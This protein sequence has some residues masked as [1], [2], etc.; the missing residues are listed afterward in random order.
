VA[1]KKPGIDRPT[2]P[3]HIGYL[4][5]PFNAQEL[6]KVIRE[7]VPGG[8]AGLVHQAMIVLEHNQALT[9]NQPLILIVDDNEI[10][11]RTLSDYLLVKANR[12][13]FAYNGIEAIE[14]TRELLPDV[15]LMDIQMPGIDGL[16]AIRRI[17]ADERTRSIPIIA[18][19]ALAMQGD[20]ARC[21]E[22]GANDYLSK[23]VSLKGLAQR[24]SELINP[25]KLLA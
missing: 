25:L 14:R 9:D 10:A 3:I 22:A 15:I 21:L 23:P 2:L 20:Q 12:V 8:T 7:I 5:F 13:A 19:T 16:E 4:E 18:L 17:R 6:R 1:E 11:L 24:I